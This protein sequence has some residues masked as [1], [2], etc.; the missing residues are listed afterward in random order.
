MNTICT[1]VN[2]EKLGTP[3]EKSTL[4]QPKLEIV[5]AQTTKDILKSVETLVHG[6]GPKPNVVKEHST[7]WIMQWQKVSKNSLHDTL[8][9]GGTATATHWENS[10][11]VQPKWCGEGGLLLILWVDSYL[12]I[13]TG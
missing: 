4:F 10:E 2:S 12:P 7:N 13:P 8:K 3:G 9:G 6:G 5:Y 11:L 1:D